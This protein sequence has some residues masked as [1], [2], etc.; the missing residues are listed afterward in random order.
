M[1]LPK[2]NQN[3]ESPLEGRP[4]SKEGKVSYGGTSDDEK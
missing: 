3:N 2:N 1:A 4:D